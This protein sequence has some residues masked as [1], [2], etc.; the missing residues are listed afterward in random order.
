MHRR[1]A[2]F[3]AFIALAACSRTEKAPEESTTPQPVRVTVADSGIKTPESALYDPQADV[4]LLSNINGTPLE[5]DGNGFIS[6]IA[7]DSGKVTALRWIA[8]GTNGV[9]LNAPK[10]MAVKGDTLF[11]ADID[12]IRMFDR[13]TGA[14]LGERTVPGATFLNDLA[15]GEDGTVYFTDTGM[16]AGPNGFADSG[17]DAIYRFG[18]RGR[19]VAIT[20]GSKLGR[21]N[22][23]I[24]DSTGI[25][26]V[27][28]GSGDVYRIDPKNGAR[29][30][31]PKPPKG[32][33]DGV[34]KTL[35]GTL[36]VSSWEGQA[37]YRLR[38][39]TWSSAVDSVQSPADIGFDAKRGTVIVPSMMTNR[40]EI[41]EVK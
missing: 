9:T 6:R 7:P 39:D 24:A 18:A 10:G 1:T 17:T 14:P 26:V 22:G 28:F 30:D 23:L 38:D 34:E 3:L 5:K 32:Q 11:V 33:L 15:V 19:A 2:L 29:T 41:R 20:K 27:T 12:V 4:Y 36:L 16:K 40:V 35:D 31:L 37:V 25:T 21:P 8:G 13:S